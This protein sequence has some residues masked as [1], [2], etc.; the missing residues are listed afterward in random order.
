MFD[1]LNRSQINK[2]NE[3]SKLYLVNY[4]LVSYLKKRI[5]VFK[6]E[7]YYIKHKIRQKK[8]RN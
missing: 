4:N 7:N 6:I 1:F 3:N 2:T 5:A 8:N